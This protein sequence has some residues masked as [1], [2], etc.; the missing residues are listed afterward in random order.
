MDGKSIASKWRWI[1]AVVIAFA[2]G[3]GVTLLVG[4]RSR[5]K[6]DLERTFD[7]IEQNYVDKV[8]RSELEESLIPQLL[9]T[10]DPHS[11]YLTREESDIDMQRLEGTF[12]GVGI[13]FNTII[14]TPVVVEVIP[15][16]PAERA[17]M[18]KGDRIIAADAEILLTKDLTAEGVRKR[19]LGKKGSVVAL[20]VLRDGKKMEIPVTR[21]EVPIQS[22]DVA[23]IAE[24]GIG[25]MRI[26]SWSRGTYGEFIAKASRLMNEGMKALVIDLRD[27]AGGY[28]EPAISV[29]NEFLRKGQLIV[30]NEGNSFPKEEYKANGKGIFPDLPLA[31]L[32][33][34]LSASSSE[35]FAAAM[36]DHDRAVI[37][38]RRTFGKGLVQRPFFLP[39]SSQI[40]L[41]IARYYTPSG[42]SI[43]KEYTLGDKEEYSR[44][45]IERMDAGEAFGVDSALFDEA[46]RYKTDAGRVVYGGYGVMPDIFVSADSTYAN[47][48]YLRLMESGAVTEFAFRF[49]D[50]N[51]SELSLCKT[52]D[53]VTSY[54]SRKGNLLSSLASYAAQHGVPQRSFLLQEAAPQIER[55][56]YAQI[57]QF[58]LGTE[59]FYRIY[60]SGDPTIEAALAEVNKKRTK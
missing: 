43:Q 10:L 48:Y 50:K 44:D 12:Y 41:T 34:E 17:G 53:E 25:L 11:T 52:P 6:S 22:I 13:S 60:F 15:S 42:R 21:D 26:G 8:D 24:K 23:Y 51:R 33:N 14:D 3:I 47:S 19:L 40:R 55:V 31:V 38:G 58:V 35:V 27:N 28:L 9:N 18:K 20:S 16:G 59:G 45:L 1:T 37:V 56:L 54:L 39:D 36:Q 5:R 49:A 7:I 32:V 57:A 46:P 2:L 29:A 30:Y 4:K